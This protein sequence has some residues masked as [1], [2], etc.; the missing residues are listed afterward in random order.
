MGQGVICWEE[1]SEAKVWACESK[2]RGG[3]LPNLML[4]EST[5]GVRGTID[6]KLRVPTFFVDASGIGPCGHLDLG[7]YILIIDYQLYFFLRKEINLPLN[8]RARVRLL[9]LG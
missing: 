2:P 3:R 1:A 9:L 6:A 4:I 5:C 8:S 7:I